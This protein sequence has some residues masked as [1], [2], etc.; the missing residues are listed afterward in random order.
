[1]SNETKKKRNKRDLS[2]VIQKKTEQ[3][4]NKPKNL[5]RKKSKFLI[6]KDQKNLHQRAQEYD[7]LVRSLLDKQIPDLNRILIF[8]YQDGFVF[9]DMQD[10]GKYSVKL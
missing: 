2:R 4:F 10:F 3:F 6:S 8:N 5:K 7:E 1:M 9:T